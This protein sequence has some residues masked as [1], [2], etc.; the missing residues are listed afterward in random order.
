[1]EEDPPSVEERKGG[2]LLTGMKGGDKTKKEADGQNKDAERD[3]AIAPEDQKEGQRE[4]EAEKRLG[5][6]G[7]DR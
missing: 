2:D 4:D 1:M 6:V 5:F 7:V 3:R